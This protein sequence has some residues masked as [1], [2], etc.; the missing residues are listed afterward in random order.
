MSSRSRGRAASGLAVDAGDDTEGAWEVWSVA[1]F[2]SGGGGVEQPAANTTA[3]I[4]TRYRRG[5][6]P[7]RMLGKCE[8]PVVPPFRF[9]LPAAGW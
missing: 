3:V 5:F 4:A 7:E 8:E 6:M 2:C 9:L 1:T